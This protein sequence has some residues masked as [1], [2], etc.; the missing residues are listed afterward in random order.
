MDGCSRSER[1]EVSTW[2]SAVGDERRGSA[3]WPS[4]P[5]RVWGPGLGVSMCPD[6]N[7]H[8]RAGPRSEASNRARPLTG[9]RQT[10][11]WDQGPETLGSAK[12]G[13]GE[14][15]SQRSTASLYLRDAAFQ[16]IR[17]NNK[18]KNTTPENASSST[19]FPQCQVLMTRI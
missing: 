13:Q 4:L 9:L 2:E 10:G 18:T 7:A 3:L 15:K 12:G 6:C 16:E 14:A 1:T 19:L 8:N 11:L 5:A 17:L